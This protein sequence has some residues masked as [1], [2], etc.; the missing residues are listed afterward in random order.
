MIGAFLH[1]CIRIYIR[2]KPRFN[3][4]FHDI[5]FIIAKAPALALYTSWGNPN[6]RAT[7]HKLYGKTSECNT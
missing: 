6:S 3:T 2:K 7:S 1:F 5:D 4:N